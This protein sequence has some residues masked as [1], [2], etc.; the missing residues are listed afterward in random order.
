MDIEN[1]KIKKLSI[2][3]ISPTETKKIYE[4][5]IK[6]APIENAVYLLEN[7]TYEDIEKLRTIDK[8][9]SLQ[10][11]YPSGN[12]NTTATYDEFIGMR[13]TIDYYKEILEGLSPAEKVACVYDIL[14][15]M[16]YQEN[17][18]DKQRARNIH[19]IVS[20]GN[21]VCVG[22]SD[23]AK[24]LLKEVDVK[25]ISVSTTFL[26]ENGPDEHH[27]RNFVRID[28]EKYDIHG[29][30]AM[31][32]TWDSDKEVAVIETETGDKQIISRPKEEQKSQIVDQYNSLV[33]YRY[34]LTPI[35]TYE[36]RFPKE[37]NP[38]LYE[39][40][41]ND[42][43]AELIKESRKLASGEL[44]SY[45]SKNSTIINQHLE[46]FDID[47]G[48]LTVEKYISAKKPSLEAFEEIIKNVRIAQGYTEEEA[49]KDTQR[50]VELHQ[51]LAE[52]NPNSPNTFFQSST[53]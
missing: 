6:N 22:Y 8:Q 7:K 15:T 32:V 53:K 20:D 31:D 19:S 44:K 5:L 17:Q 45:Q 37:E 29:L 38:K 24:Q 41:K 2:V 46:L 33:L 4:Y 21:I 49:K 1:G 34:F 40:Y 39:I 11:K 3:D 42:S 23:F 12:S 18:N 16:R 25:S 28:D 51:M 30:Y 9:T 36:Q 35:E 47:E 52:Q 10:I 13:A 48:P 26:N 50:V 27:Q 14:K 43:A